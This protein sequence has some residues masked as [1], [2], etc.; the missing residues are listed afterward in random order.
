MSGAR[1]SCM[2]S[3]QRSKNMSVTS[4]SGPKKKINT[5]AHIRTV[6]KLLEA[7]VLTVITKLEKRPRIPLFVD[8]RAKTIIPMVSAKFVIWN[9]ITQITKI[10]YRNRGG[11]E[12]KNS[13]C[14]EKSRISSSNNWRKIPSQ[15]KSRK[16]KVNEYR[17]VAKFKRTIINVQI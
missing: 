7:C 14:S 16:R 15:F 17:S 5:Y 11:N 1:T 3:F 13:G 6:K 4:R 10:T 8:I 2:F 12:D 9:H